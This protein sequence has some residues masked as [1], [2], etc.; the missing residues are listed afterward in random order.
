MEFISSAVICVNIVFFI[1]DFLTALG[2][3]VNS[4]VDTVISNIKHQLVIL[5]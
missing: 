1:F 2:N 3:N 5:F 4:F